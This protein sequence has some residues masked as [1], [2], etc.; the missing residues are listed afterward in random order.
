MGTVPSPNIVEA[1][2]QIAEAPQNALAE[3]ARVAA[4][5]QAT[6]QQAAMAPLQQQQAQQQIEMQ[7]RQMADQDAL[8]K[9]IAQY[10]PDK[11][12]LAD[13]PKLITQN[14]GSGQAALAAQSGLVTQRQNLAKLSDE[15]FSHQQKIADLVQG[16]HDKVT[17]APPELKQNVYQQGLQTLGQ[18]GV[19]VSKEPLQY[20]G[21]DVF[22]QHLPV[23]RLHS[24]IVAEAAKDRELTAKEQAAIPEDERNFQA[25]YKPWLESHGAQP[26]AALELKARDEFRQIH[27]PPAVDQQEMRDWLSKNPGKGPSDFMAYKA[28]LVPQFNFNL[29]A[30]GVPVSGAAAAVAQGKTAP[31]DL[32]AAIPANIRPTVMALVE[33]RQSPPG[34]FALKTP[35]WQNVMN[36]VYSI[37]P[38]W[39]EQRAQ[40]RKAY[41]LGPQ[42]KE[43]NAIN[44]AMGHVGVLGDA[45]DALNNSD[46]RLLNKVAN[47]LGVEIGNTPVTTFNTIVHRVGPE[48]SKA[49]IGAGGS[50]GERGADEKDFD[51]NL[52]PSQLKTNVAVT[53]QLLRSKISSLE[54]QWDQNAAPGLQSFQDRFIMPE[55]RR[56]LDKWSGTAPAAGG[57]GVIRARDPQGRLHEAP[58]GTPLP[59]GWKAE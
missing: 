51:P 49:Y 40:L 27:K 22:A 11:H 4:L 26:S 45:I 46:V 28:K 31:K 10:D 52:G 29:Q 14:G 20:P 19:D 47:R 33:G 53:A 59:K 15:Q 58:A 5:K 13:I 48:L 21:D 1:A 25:Y 37:D 50:A 34:S 17:D 2:G 39:N 9:A 54:N 55:A 7:R 24:E 3:Y 32:Q 57:G 16:V 44:T 43:I 12:T 56:Q 6:Q 23:I 8:T 38:Q 30:Q 41:T 42:S 18:A 35:Y 36:Q